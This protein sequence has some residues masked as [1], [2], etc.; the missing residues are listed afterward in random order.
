MDDF[1]KSLKE[2]GEVGFV[3]EVTGAIAFVTGLPQVRPDELVIFEN[4]EIGQVFTLKPDAVEVLTF[5]KTPILVGTK[6]ARSGRQFEVPVGEELLSNVIDPFG[7]SFENHKL[8]KKPGQMRPIHS[9]PPGIK[10]RKSI[11][12][13]FETGVSIVDLM[14]PLGRGQRELVIGDRKTG[15]SNFLLQTMVF[16]AKQ[17][18]I[19]IYAAIGKN[20]IDIKRTEEYFIK[21]GVIN[22]VI[23]IASSSQD[24]PEIIHLTPYSAMTIAE[25]FRDQGHDV[26]L[27]LDDLSTHAKF[28]REISL[29]GR[30]FPGRDS[31]PGDMF[32]MH[33]RLLERAGNFATEKGDVSITCLPVVETLQGDLSGFIQTNIMSMTDG[34]IYFDSNLFSQ[35]RRP[36]VNPF[37][38]VT[39][40][41]HQTQSDSK[42]SISRE[43]LTFLTLFDKMQNIVH[44]GSELSENVKI[45]LETGGKILELF[46]QESDKVIPV[47]VQ[48]IALSLL[49]G[50]D[51]KSMEISKLT[52]YKEKISE[53][54]QSDSNYKQMVDEIVNKSNSFNEM[55]SKVRENSDRFNVN[56]PKQEAP[57]MPNFPKK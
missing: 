13:Y 42:R 56:L 21:N 27:V 41:G 32:Y 9:A 7:N 30:R 8:F 39:R 53:Q 4:G 16:A 20:K 2:I 49:W 36:S 51:F 45:V 50:D 57:V 11:K 25:Y 18:D 37:L 29:I 10:S 35:G 48:S 31:Y 5:S 46:D 33:A 26:L 14:V 22:R 3:K 44:F 52:Y 19:C 15:K 55:L 17:G 38:S 34:H 23:I 1:Q 40:V 6:V 43:L 12:R 54:Y 28:Y 47:N 24:Q